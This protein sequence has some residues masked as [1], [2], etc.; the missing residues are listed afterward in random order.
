VKITIKKADIEESGGSDGSGSEEEEE[1][2][3]EDEQNESLSSRRKLRNRND[4]NSRGSS[5]KSSKSVSPAPPPPPAQRP[6]LLYTCKRCYKQYHSRFVLKTHMKA[7]DK[8]EQGGE[9]KC[10]KYYLY[11]YHTAT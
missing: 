11:Y 8:V 1:E 7:H 3:K 9:G 6:K 2:E 4:K 5:S 10:D